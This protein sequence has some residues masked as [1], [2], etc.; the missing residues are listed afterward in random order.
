MTRLLSAGVL[1]TILLA[2]A[3]PALADDWKSFYDAGEKARK[4]GDLD[5]AVL[6]M[7]R[8][9]VEA[10]KSGAASHPA[11]QAVTGL[12]SM[13][14][15]QERITEA[16]LVLEHTLLAL[17]R[18]PDAAPLDLADV[19]DVLGTVTGAQK[20]YTEAES[21]LKRA[22]IVREK[23]LGADH[24][25]VADTL[26]SLAA[27]ALVNKNYDDAET[28]ARRALK[29]REKTPEADPPALAKIY[30]TLAGLNAVQDNYAE[31]E[32]FFRRALA[33]QE[34][35]LG[36]DNIE[37]A[38]TLMEIASV[39]IAPV[40][41]GSMFTFLDDLKKP[42]QAEAD[43]VKSAANFAETAA[44][45]TRALAIREK[46]L[47]A[48]DPKCI[49]L[50]QMLFAGYMAQDDFVHTEP[51]LKR[52]I[53]AKEKTLGPDG[54][55]VIMYQTFLAEGA[56]KHHRYGEAIPLLKRLIA[57]GDAPKEEAEK[58]GRVGPLTPPLTLARS[59]VLLVTTT[60]RTSPTTSPASSERPSASSPWPTTPPPDRAQR[61]SPSSRARI[62]SPKDDARRIAR[63]DQ[64]VR[65]RRP[66]GRRR[67]RSPARTRRPP[68]IEL[69]TRIAR[70]SRLARRR[71]R[72]DRG[73]HA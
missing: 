57:V 53:A 7:K 33:I 29:I 3:T 18:S 42:A 52:L 34:K 4:A 50:V 59:P 16:G 45:L 21:L 73:L 17:A 13:Y 70:L 51:F 61:T 32:S 27:I 8:A 62:W 14:L 38:S 24:G 58:T 31:A 40:L 39:R 11:V 49:E 23:A 37:V 2:L 36:R 20:N 72:S 64:A 54:D 60:P 43:K 46:S 67:A 30:R 35:T 56:L 69:Q 48:D 26:V 66:A 9:L 5:E 55:E 65:A 25:D 12:C 41:N 10:E 1:G 44:L 68:D 47:G 63:I 19:Y 71:C 6:L 28:L 22:L 15:A